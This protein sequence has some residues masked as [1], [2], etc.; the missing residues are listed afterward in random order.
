MIKEVLQTD[1]INTDADSSIKGIGLQKIRAAE[2]LL[3]ALL[4]NKRAVFC[5][6]EHVDDVLEVDVEQETT[7]Y[8]AEQNKSYSTDFSMNSHEVKN[9]LRIFFDNWYGTVEASESIRFVFYTNTNIKKENK[10]GVLKD[11]EESLPEEPLLQLL[12]DKKYKEAFPFVLPIFK[13][14]YLEQHKKHIANEE[15]IELYEKILDSMT[16]EKWEKFFDLIEWNF[17]KPNEI[18]VRENVEKSVGE[19]CLKYGVNQKYASIVVAQMLDMIESRKFESDFLCRIVH[20][21]EIKSLFLEFAQEAKIQE[22]LDPMYKKWDDIH[23]DDVRNINEKFLCVCPDFER[24]SLEELEEEYIDG[25]YEQSHHQNHRQV[26]AY[27]YRVYKTCQKN[28]KKFLKEQKGIFSQDKIEA[29][30]EEL[31]WPFL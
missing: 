18:E 5:T 7:N 3:R 28:I 8:T 14:Y 20:V 11:I 12:C 27:N 26:K 9:S 29:F 22:K 15:D 31:T 17:G 2:R 23:C 21:G 4:E 30:I 13:K 10:V 1:Q 24:D 6:I 25:A 19:I 16:E